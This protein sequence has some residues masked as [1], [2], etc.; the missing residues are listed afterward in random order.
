MF[1]LFSTAYPCILDVNA[2]TC[3]F[4]IPSVSA[5]RAVAV[6]VTDPNFPVPT[7]S[8]IFAIIFAVFGSFMVIVRDYVWVGKLAWVRAY[9][10]NMMCIALAFV[11]PQTVYGTAELMGAIL[12]YVWAKKN[13]KS[14]DV[15]GYAIA[16]GLIAGEGIG[17]VINAIFQ[18]AG[19]AGDKYGSQ[20]ACPGDSC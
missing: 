19:I 10:P 7:S 15:L 14:F 9:H 6:A 18:V 8:G 20:I 12:A 4:G 1:V 16:A 3:A 11:L 17:G 13:P 2:K 5:W